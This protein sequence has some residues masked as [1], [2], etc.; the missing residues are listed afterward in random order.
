MPP[1]EEHPSSVDA[2]IGQAVA[3]SSR[4]GWPTRE[5]DLMLTRAIWHKLRR[6]QLSPTGRGEALLRQLE[7]AFAATGGD[8][9]FRAVLCRVVLR[10]AGLD[11]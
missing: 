2:L 4:S 7:T 5:A 3:W 6:C 1:H 8:P 11:E 9:L 10:A